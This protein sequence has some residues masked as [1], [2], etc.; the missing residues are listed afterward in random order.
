[1]QNLQVISIPIKSRREL[2]IHADF[3]SFNVGI[4]ENK[5]IIIQFNPEIIIINDWHAHSAALTLKNELNLPLYYQFFRIFSRDSSFFSDPSE[6]T[7]LREIEISLAQAATLCIQLSEDTKE[8]CVNN[9][10]VPTEVLY[11]PLK[12]EYIA[13][14]SKLAASKPKFFH[15]PVRFMTFVR[16]SPE[17]QLE[18]MLQVLAACKFDWELLISGE[19]VNESYWNKINDLI[20]QL[21]IQKK[22]HFLGV[23]PVSELIKQL[24]DSDAYIH[25]ARYEPFGISIMEAALTGIPVILDK[26]PKIGAGELLVEDESCIRLDYLQPNE[27]AKEITRLIENLAHWEKI[28]NNGQKIASELRVSKSIEKLLTYISRYRT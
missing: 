2:G 14:F 16:I 22:V 6:F 26:S 1:M 10:H 5:E 4:L 12:N 25:P 21:K 11:P 23:L 7:R 13:E 24:F 9:F 27:A 28:G 20:V 18:E 3:I 8:W 17:K 19:R 15:N